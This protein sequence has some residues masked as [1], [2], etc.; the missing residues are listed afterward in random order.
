MDPYLVA[1]MVRTSKSDMV[2]SRIQYQELPRLR[3]VFPYVQMTE[4]IK[5]TLF[6]TLYSLLLQLNI[7]FLVWISSQF[8]DDKLSSMVIVVL[9]CKIVDEPVY[10]QFP[11]CF[12]LRFRVRTI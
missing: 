12:L 3:K 8:L 6:V 2:K 9:Q 11:I 7:T 10:V 4:T 5:G 1:V